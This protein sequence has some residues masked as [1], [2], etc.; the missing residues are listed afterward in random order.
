MAP[1]LFAGG[2]R[3]AQGRALTQPLEGRSSMAQFI[4]LEVALELASALGPLLTAVQQHDRDLA[5]QLRRAGASVASCFS[6]GA[7]R[8][9]GDRQHLF[10]TAGGS[11]AEVR[12]QLQIAVAWSYVADSEARPAIALADRCAALSWRLTR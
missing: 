2:Q 6:E 1:A 8:T 12:T 4:A 11:A 5:S 9:G 7:L 10:R 3:P